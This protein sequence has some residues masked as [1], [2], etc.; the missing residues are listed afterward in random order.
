[1]DMIIVASFTSENLAL[2]NVVP[3]GHYCSY[4]LDDECKDIEKHEVE[5]ES[6]G[7]NSQNLCARGE[8][9][10]HSAQDHINVCVD[11]ERCELHYDKRSV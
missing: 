4:S 9:V 6:P 11:P 1:M 5:A 10:Y 2:G 8:V 7:F 3:R